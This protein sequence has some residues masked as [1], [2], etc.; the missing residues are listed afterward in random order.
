MTFEVEKRL[1]VLSQS[2]G[3]TKEVNL[4]SWNDRKPQIDIRKWSGEKPLK[5]ITLTYEEAEELLNLLKK[6]L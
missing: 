3:Y 2:A 6:A 5:G 1:G 4:V